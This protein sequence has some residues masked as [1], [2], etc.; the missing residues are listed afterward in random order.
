MNGYHC[1]Y[2][3]QLVIELVLLPCMAVSFLKSLIISAKHSGFTPERV[4]LFDFF[5]RAKLK[6]LKA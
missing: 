5:L 1:F 4:I 3:F 6:C 2:L